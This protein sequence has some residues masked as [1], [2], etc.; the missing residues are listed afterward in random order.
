MYFEL[1]TW[2]GFDKML[3]STPLHTRVCIHID[4]FVFVLP[5]GCCKNKQPIYYYIHRWVNVT[6]YARS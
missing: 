6:E 2:I 4:I 5:Q 3:T 1:Y